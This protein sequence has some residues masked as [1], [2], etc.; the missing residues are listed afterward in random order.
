MDRAG[1]RD[2]MLRGVTSGGC[3]L[4][5]LVFIAVT[6]VARGPDAVAVRLLHRLSLSTHIRWR[7]LVPVRYP[8]MRR[9]LRVPLAEPL[10]MRSGWLKPTQ[11]VLTGGAWSS[12]LQHGVRHCDPWAAGK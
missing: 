10:P 12:W 11:A 5:R 4:V 3:T 2:G 9:M 1:F 6:D 7:S 8:P